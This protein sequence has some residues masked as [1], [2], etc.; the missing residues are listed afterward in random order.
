MFFQVNRES[1]SSSKCDASFVQ[2][3]LNITDKIVP[4]VKERP[5]GRMI[6]SG[7]GKVHTVATDTG[8]S[9]TCH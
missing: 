4:I 5:H 1:P 3:Q 8:N 2:N 9:T 6:S 7:N